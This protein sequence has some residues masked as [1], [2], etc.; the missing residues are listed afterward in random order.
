MVKHDIAPNKQPWATSRKEENCWNGDITQA[1]W[2]EKSIEN[3]SAS[4]SWRVLLKSFLD[5]EK[6]HPGKS[7]EDSALH[8][9]LLGGYCNACVT[10]TV[11]R[12]C[13]ERAGITF[14]KL[15]DHNHQTWQSG[16]ITGGTNK[17]I[18]E[19]SSKGVEGPIPRLSLSSPQSTVA[20]GGGGSGSKTVGL[21][22]LGNWEGRRKYWK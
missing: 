5:K 15:Q 11:M 7:R 1:S 19:N 3:V 20:W 13:Q 14:F 8:T 2:F 6:R 18:S 4:S 22:F 10:V 21:Q 12:W 9:V 16:N 17:T